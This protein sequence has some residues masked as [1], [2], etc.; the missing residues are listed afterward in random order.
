MRDLEI[1]L[2]VNACEIAARVAFS[3]ARVLL[4]HLRPIL[5]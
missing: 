5:H 3:I 2:Y 4:N 1:R